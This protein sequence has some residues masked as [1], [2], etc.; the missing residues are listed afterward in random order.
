ME[1]NEQELKTVCQNIIRDCLKFC[2]QRSNEVAAFLFMIDKKLNQIYL[3]DGETTFVKNS[4]HAECCVRTH[5]NDEAREEF[6]LNLSQITDL[7][8]M[9]KACTCSTLDMMMQVNGLI[10]EEGR[11][12]FYGLVMK[13]FQSYN[14]KI[15]LTLSF[16]ANYEAVMSR[17]RD[18]DHN[19]Q[20]MGV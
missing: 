1:I 9:D 3:E 11:E 2:D 19:I 13:L 8:L 5:A 15:H 14:F 16:S 18:T 12:I 6:A 10:S 7:E 17:A 20:A 4:K